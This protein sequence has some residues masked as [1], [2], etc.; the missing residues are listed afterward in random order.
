[1]PNKKPTDPVHPGEIL[2][3]D[4]MKPAGISINALALEIRVPASRIHAIVNETRGITADTAL[5]LGRYF[6]TTS[7][8]WMNLQSDFD[9]RTAAN[10]SR[11][12]IERSIHPRAAA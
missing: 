10:A 7:K 12:E 11:E 6:S 2:L 4:F 3:E 8:L 5:R 1:M 9:L